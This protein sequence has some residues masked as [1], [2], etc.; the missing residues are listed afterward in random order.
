M[1]HRNRTV[2]AL[3]LLGISGSLVLGCTSYQ[4]MQ[5][6]V[7][8]LKAEIKTLH[9]DLAAIQR[10]LVGRGASPDS[11]QLPVTIRIVGNPMLGKKDAPITIAE[12]SDY[13][14]PYCRK[15]FQETFSVLKTEYID[16]GKVRYVFRDFPLEQLHANAR[17]AHEAAYC[18]GDQGQ[19]WEMHDLLFRQQTGMHVERLQQLAGELNLA[20]ETFS[21]CITSGQHM[22]EIDHNL[23]EGQSFSVSGTPTFFIGKSTSEEA[24]NPVSLVGAQPIQ[25]FRN[26]ID[27]FLKSQEP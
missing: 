25:A 3:L 26:A 2:I 14:C 22:N 9:K 6:D 8:D 24:V 21:A 15:F 4:Q 17:K 5:S 1:D 13:Q 18:A 19:Y 27:S 7:K 20:P 23:Q 12:F 16:T 11:L 10:V